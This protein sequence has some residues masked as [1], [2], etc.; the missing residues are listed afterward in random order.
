[1]LLKD[2]LE[3]FGYDPYL[4]KIG[5]AEKTLTAVRVGRFATR[6][7]AVQ[8]GEDLKSRYGYEYYVVR[9]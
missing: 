2:Q 9:P 4:Q 5:T 6:A 7:E 1:M 8:L 3:G